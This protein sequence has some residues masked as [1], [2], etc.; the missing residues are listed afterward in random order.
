MHRKSAAI[1][2]ASADPPG[3]SCE[4]RRLGYP[5]ESEFSAAEGISNRSR[6]K[7]GG[8][9]ARSLLY[10]RHSLRRKVPSAICVRFTTWGECG[11][12]WK[13]S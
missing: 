9:R 12:P 13:A 2:A 10:V 5:V 6:P 1:A 7:S 11:C 4:Y 3:L 8:R